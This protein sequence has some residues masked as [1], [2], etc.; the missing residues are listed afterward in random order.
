MNE[1]GLLASIKARLI[2]QTWTGSS[3]VVFPTGSVAIVPAL[4]D[5][6]PQALN[7]MRVPFCL[8]EP[9]TADSDP[10]HDEEPDFIRFTANVVILTAIPGD[11]VGEGAVVGA[12]KTGG[13]DHSEGRGILELEQEFYNAVG[14]LND[15]E[16]IN[17]QVRQKTQQGAVR[18]SPSEWIAYRIYSLETWGTASGIGSS[19]GGGATPPQVDALYAA[20]D[21]GQPNDVNYNVRD[22]LRGFVTVKDFGAVGDGVTDDTAA[23]QAAINSQI[24]SNRTGGEVYFPV[25]TYKITSALIVLNASGV[26]LR[27]AGGNYSAAKITQ[28]TTGLASIILQNTENCVIGGFSISGLGSSDVDSIGI[29]IKWDGTNGYNGLA[30]SVEHC[31]ISNVYTGIAC[32]ALAGDSFSCAENTFHKVMIHDCGREG[33]RLNSTNSQ[34]QMFRDCRITSC[35]T[36][37]NALQGTP[38]IHGGI[39][40]LNDVADIYLGN[41][42]TAVTIDSAY[43]EQSNLFIDTAGPSASA[44]PTTLRGCS[45]FSHRTADSV[46]I[47]YKLGGPLVLIGNEIGITSFPCK[48]N[49]SLG[50]GTS[51]GQVISIGNTYW[52]TGSALS[53]VL[54]NVGAGGNCVLSSMSDCIKNTSTGRVTAINA[55]IFANEN[56]VNFKLLRTNNSNASKNS[57]IIWQWGNNENDALNLWTMSNDFGGHDH[58]WFLFNNRTNKVDIR[59]MND[60]EVRLSD[61]KHLFGLTY[62]KLFGA[63]T[64]Q[65]SS[66]QTLAAANAL[67]A[68]AGKVRVVGSGGAV[69]LTSTPTIAAGSDGQIVY[70]QGTHAT[71]TVTLQDEASLAGTKLKLGAATRAL[72]KGSLL[73]LMYDTTDAFWYEVSFKA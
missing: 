19:S 6:I 62:A 57:S 71:N 50:S 33:V 69:T 21:P 1:S 65:S 14:K 37:I 63:V 12:N 40:A 46:S 54:V 66:L 8:V 26:R 10:I 52:A 53:D 39:F 67:L 18:K 2:A 73:G 41:P 38:L 11:V 31:Q 35:H 61:D 13:T 3:N 68:N 43:T 5:A 55:P 48:V 44:Y 9:G 32:G 56:T 29:Q 17:L 70:I 16:S 27:G 24:F 25:G 20:Y 4:A 22:R 28:A 47:V 30:N 36:G 59:A 60:D 51:L 23:I 45:I 58:D 15:L 64:F 34:S 72:A 7:T 42:L 49:Y